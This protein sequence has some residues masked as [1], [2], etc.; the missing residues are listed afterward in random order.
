MKENEGPL[1]HLGNPDLHRLRTIL[2][3]LNEVIAVITQSI[4][5]EKDVGPAARDL[6]EV[7]DVLGVELRR[8]PGA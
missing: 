8:Y 3:S 4:Q 6:R 7:I 1:A 2:T 5:R